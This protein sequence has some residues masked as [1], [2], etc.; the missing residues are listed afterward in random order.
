MKLKMKILPL[1]IAA[2]MGFSLVGLGSSAMA[3]NGR[4][5]RQRRAPRYA[6]H[7]GTRYSRNANAKQAGL[8]EQL[9]AMQ[10]ELNKLE[11]MS[12]QNTSGVVQDFPGSRRNWF[13]RI[14]VT[15]LV[16]VDAGFS[17]K[18]PRI[19]GGSRGRYGSGGS[20]DLALNNATL[21]VDAN[22]NR[23]IWGHLAVLYADNRGIYQL[24]D[25]NTSLFFGSQNGREFHSRVILDEGFIQLRDFATSPWFI[26]A[27]RFYLPFG[28]YQRYPITET[29]PQ[30]L[31]MTQSTALEVGFVSTRGLSGMIYGF[32]GLPRNNIALPVVGGN[33]SGNRR[34][35]N[36]FGA[37]L[38]Y[39][40][41]SQ[42]TLNGKVDVGYLYN[43][44]DV[45]FISST[46]TIGP[47]TSV[48]GVPLTNA[49]GQIVP[50]L[51]PI[52]AGSVGVIGN[53]KR[54][55]GIAADGFLYYGPYDMHANFAGALARFNTLDVV[56]NNRGAEPRALDLGAGY[57]FNSYGRPTHVGVSWQHSWGAS[58]LGL[59]SQVAG[60]GLPLNRVQ[61]TLTYNIY[62]ATDI[63]A[64]VRWDDD[65]NSNGVTGGT[66]KQAVTGIIRLS[67]GLV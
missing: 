53:R 29:L 25:H 43:M 60:G 44:N 54:V 10:S 23:Y 3:A 34:N 38:A 15:G 64:Q 35:W 56:Y 37:Q 57:A 33:F 12:N 51:P 13:R 50:G 9:A 58:R 40:F 16:N 46:F 32:R 24:Y 18:T 27:G 42:Q 59:G 22:P 30:Q 6:A 48:L 1:T 31:E 11:I 41:G 36:N 14:S 49:T 19:V 67:L 28:D 2:A 20:S 7:P 5:K 17:S 65:Y 21:F 66:G 4:Y 45:D 63:A 52:N 39:H 61:G 8:R 47:N 26:Q 62:R 55:P